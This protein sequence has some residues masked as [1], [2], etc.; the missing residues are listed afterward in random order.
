MGAPE[1]HILNTVSFYGRAI[2]PQ[3]LKPWHGIN[4]MI[5][6]ATLITAAPSQPRN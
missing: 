1:N 3:F 5:M 4:E 6:M 2:K